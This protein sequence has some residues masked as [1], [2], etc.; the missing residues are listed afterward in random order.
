MQR[1]TVTI[2]GRQRQAPLTRAPE[3]GSPS[4]QVDVPSV[5]TEDEHVPISQCEH[6]AEAPSDPDG[7]DDVFGCVGKRIVV[8]IDA[9]QPAGADIPG[10]PPTLRTAGEKVVTAGDDRSR[11]LEELE[12]VHPAR[13]A[14]EQPPL[15]EPS[16]SVEN[17]ARRG[18]CGGLVVADGT[19]HRAS[20]RTTPSDRTAAARGSRKTTADWSVRP[21]VAELC[22]RTGTGPAGRLGSWMSCAS[23]PNV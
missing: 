17:S 4:F 2:A 5:G 12:I 19:S 3:P 21:R 7:T 1:R 10:Q 18:A 14:A 23:R 6:T 16:V 11:S 13:M 9:D 15:G 20:A 22:T 8:A